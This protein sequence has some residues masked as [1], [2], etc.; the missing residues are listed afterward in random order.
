MEYK[1]SF[2]QAFY[3]TASR[4]L[5]KPY[6]LLFHTTPNTVNG[7]SYADVY[8][9]SLPSPVTG[10]P[11]A[12][13]IHG[14]GFCQGGADEG[15][16]RQ[17]Q[18]AAQVLKAGIVVVSLEYR[19]LPHVILA[20]VCEDIRA[21]W[22]WVQNGSLQ[23]DL[24]VAGAPN[25]IIDSGRI[26]GWGHSA[27][28]SLLSILGMTVPS[29]LRCVLNFFGTVNW[30]HSTSNTWPLLD[31]LTNKLLA[32][33]AS[34]STRNRLDLDL[35]NDKD[36][37]QQL[38]LAYIL[39]LYKDIGTLRAV[40]HSTD[41]ENP[42]HLLHPGCPPFYHVQGSKDHMVS[43]DGTRRFHQKLLDIGVESTLVIIEGAGHGWLV[44]KD[45]PGLLG[46]TWKVDESALAWMISKIKD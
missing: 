27:G 15:I 14:G 29:R 26:G 19:K 22:A 37:E 31:D 46:E 43:C 20:Q 45:G 4:S 23:Q 12:L 39:E 35:Q 41:Q 16:L 9:P 7:G 30:T 28:A 17:P 21:G 3:D 38:R 44:E 42:F 10:Y 32:G 8:V 2:D 11:V 18:Q 13:Y 25:V 1:A 34:T 36:P 6:H 5:P 33:P 40:L 24:G